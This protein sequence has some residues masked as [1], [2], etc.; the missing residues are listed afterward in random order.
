MNY[1][2][3]YKRE[4]LENYKQS[5]YMLK[6]SKVIDKMAKMLDNFDIDEEIC[7]NV[8]KCDTSGNP[9]NEV[10]K[11]CIKEYFWKEAEKE[12][13]SENV[14]DIIIFE[15]SD[16]QK[17]P[18][19]IWKNGNFWG[20]SDELELL[21]WDSF[22]LHNNYVDVSIDYIKEDDMDC[23]IEEEKRNHVIDWLKMSQNLDD[24]EISL[25][26]RRDF[27]NIYQYHKR[28]EVEWVE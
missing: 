15:F 3:E 21:I 16:K 27:G 2:K 22:C 18:A 9:S 10:C 7:K 19:K 6:Q 1:E 23:E 28:N 26:K 4:L 14:A 12:M 13:K 5:E 8:E 17:R 20:S 25:L 11:N 24:K